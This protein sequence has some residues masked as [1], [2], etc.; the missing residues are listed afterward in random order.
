MPLRNGGLAPLDN[1]TT[2]VIPV[3]DVFDEW[4]FP[5]NDVADFLALC[6]AMIIGHGGLNRLDLLRAS[7]MREGAER[8]QLISVQPNINDADMN[9]NG[10]LAGMLAKPVWQCLPFEIV[11][12]QTT[13]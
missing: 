3:S 2:E 1:S 7:F 5:M 4:L 13:I 9:R 6:A 12:E 10:L 8:P 11:L